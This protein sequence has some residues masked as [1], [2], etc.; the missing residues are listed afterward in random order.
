[1]KNILKGILFSTAL[2]IGASSLSSCG[3][4]FSDPNAGSLISQI[5]TTTLENGNTK[6]TI[7]FEDEY[8]DP[9][10]FIIPR[11]EDGV[12]GNGISDITSTP[13]EDG[14]HTIVSI[15]FTDEGYSDRTFTVKNGVSLSKVESFVD[16]E[17]GKYMLKVIFTDGTESEPFEMPRGKDGN[18]IISYEH[19]EKEDGSQVL[20]FKFSQSEDVVVTV[21]APSDGRGIKNI[22]SS[23]S[24]EMYILTITYS[25]D[26]EETITFNKPVPAKW[27]SGAGEPGFNFGEVGDYYLDTDHNDIWAKEYSGWILK[28]D[29]VSDEDTYKI[30]FNLNDSEDAKARMP[31]YESEYFIKR[32]DYFSTSVK[33]PLPSPTRDG[34]TFDGWYTS[35]VITPT[36][37]H[38]TELTP[39]F[40]EITLYAKWIKN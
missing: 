31:G 39:V 20:T 24:D 30:T 22:V 1:M 7:I 34:Y 33:A 2:L 8:K 18:G 13:S 35:A 19:E 29:F 36:T 23:E 4:F 17:T 40:G 25:D 28:V 37:G 12:S 5:K 3:A 10:E 11:G 32:G 6:V 14:T 21:P 38:F 16:E 9:V 26:K 27:Y 15:S